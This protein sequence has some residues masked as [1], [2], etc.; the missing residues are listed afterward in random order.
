MDNKPINQIFDEL[1]IG[2]HDLE[3]TFT[4]SNEFVE[5]VLKE[6]DEKR[7]NAYMVNIIKR[8]GFAPIKTTM[9]CDKVGEIVTKWKLTVFYQSTNNLLI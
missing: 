2:K 9:R 1:L 6:M 8:K 7:R 5:N 4:F 3:Q